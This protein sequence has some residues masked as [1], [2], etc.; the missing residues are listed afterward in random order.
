MAPS[1]H[2]WGAGVGWLMV[3]LHPEV[4]LSYA[5]L[6]VPSAIRRAPD[7]PGLIESLIQKFG[8][9]NGKTAVQARSFISELM[10]EFV[11]QS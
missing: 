2:D 10:S 7:Q 8:D 1:Q 5:A 3:H 4:F 9:P 6:S 11:C